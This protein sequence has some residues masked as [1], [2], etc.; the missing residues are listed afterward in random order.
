METRM[1]ARWGTP[2]LAILLGILFF[3]ASALGGQPGV[4]L[5]MFAVMAIWS[6]FLIVFGGRSETVGALAGRPAD[7][8][9]AS[10]NIVATAAAGTVALLVG[11]VGF[12][13]EIAHGQSGNDFAIVVAAGG[14]GYIAALVWLRWR[15]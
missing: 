14:I 4:G 7:E 6:G 2:A 15:R 1:N 12:L 13:W 10:F 9:F 8:R 5:A 11:L 3:V